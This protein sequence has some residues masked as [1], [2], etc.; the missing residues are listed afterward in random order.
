MKGLIFIPDINGFTNFVR[1]VDAELGAYIIQDLLSAMIVNNPLR[2]EVSEVEGDAILFYKLGKP[3]PVDELVNAF[4]QMQQAFYTKYEQYKRQ[5][6]LQTELSLKLIVHYGDII[7]YDIRGFRKLYGETIIEAHRL[8]KSG[9]G[10]NDY[11]LVTDDYME[12]L[13]TGNAKVS[14]ALTSTRYQVMNDKKI[15]YHILPHDQKEIP[16]RTYA[17]MRA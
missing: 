1:S 5:Y 16:F 10:A 8:L 14:N 2:L 15:G 6:N 11:I 17:P 3:H 9:H 7:L 4:S 12:A 13:Q